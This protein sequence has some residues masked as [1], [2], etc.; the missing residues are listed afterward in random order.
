MSA[1]RFLEWAKELP[2]ELEFWFLDLFELEDSMSISFLKCQ[3]T[4]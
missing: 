1:K 4:Q 3:K 2:E